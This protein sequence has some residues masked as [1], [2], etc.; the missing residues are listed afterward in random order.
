MKKLD[1]VIRKL[2]KAPSVIWVI[3]VALS[4][5]FLNLYDLLTTVDELIAMFDDML[6]DMAVEFTGFMNNLEWMFYVDVAIIGLIVFELI[7]AIV[8]RYMYNRGFVSGDAVHFKTAARVAYILANIIIGAFS[9]IS[10]AAPDFFY[11]NQF[12]IRII[13][14]TAFFLAAYLAVKESIINPKLKGTALQRIITVYFAIE[15]ALNILNFIIALTAEEKDTHAII[16]RGIAL[17][18]IALLAAG[19]YFLI[20]KPL[21]KQEKE[22][23]EIIIH[24]DTDDTP[25][26]PDEVFRG[27]GF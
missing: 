6:S 27:Y 5:I 2:E 15:G 13:V 18:V 1:S 23:V 21:I 7:L 26:P 24:R 3:L 12:I 11:Y 25:P 14:Y 10:Y 9:F 20:I 16:A 19:I 4:C 17:G 22:Y 8:Y